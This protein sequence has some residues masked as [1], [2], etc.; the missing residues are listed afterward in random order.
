MTEYELGTTTM[1]YLAASSANLGLLSIGM[2]LG[3]TSPIIPKLRNIDETPLD[4]VI[5]DDQESW[6]GSLIALGAFI[7]PLYSGWAAGRFGRKWCIFSSGV[8][9][10]VG[11][12]LIA[13]ATNVDQIYAARFIFG[14]AVGQLFTCV[15]MYVGEISQ[16]EIRGTL[17]SFFQMFIVTGV[18]LS[19]VIGPYVDYATLAIISIVPVIAFVVTF[20]FMPESPSY[21]I[22][23]NQR[24]AAEETLKRLRNKSSEGVQ[25]ELDEIQKG[26]EQN[27]TTSSIKDLWKSK[28]NIRAMFIGCSMTAFD[29]LSGIDFVLFYLEPIFGVTDSGL[30]PEIS[31]IIIGVVQVIASC[32]TPLV[33]DRLGRRIMLMVTAII[34]T[35]SQVALGIFFILDDNDSPSVEYITWLPVVSLM[36]FI[37]AYNMGIGSLAW[38][39]VGE[40]FDQSIK[41]YGSTFAASFNWLIGFLITKFFGSVADALGIYYAFWIFGVFCLISFFFGL[42]LLPETKG[43]SLQEIQIMLVFES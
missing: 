14:L 27:S 43:K 33:V 36:V 1:Q 38:I 40:L 24:G 42:F 32:I 39:V 31:T 6:I 41:S 11:W 19:Y 17:G 21:L 16:D 28:A 3:W 9:L 22:G 4:N 30:S 20:F 13:T 10:L 29:Q 23:K 15:P 5:S 37:T 2:A 12:I 26:N 18:L 7:S 35:L 34:L 25:E 8:P